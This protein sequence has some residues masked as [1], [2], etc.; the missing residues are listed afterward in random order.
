MT[1]GTA[2]GYYRCVPSA[3]VINFVSAGK[4]VWSRKAPQLPGWL[5]THVC[6]GEM[7]IQVIILAHLHPFA[8]SN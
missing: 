6:Q 5:I 7:H 2:D 3:L 1:A 4:S 8:G